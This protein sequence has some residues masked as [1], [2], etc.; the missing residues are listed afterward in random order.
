[1]SSTTRSRRPWRRLAVVALLVVCF[2]TGCA[3]TSSKWVALR[4]T[5]RNPLSDTLGLLTRQGPKPTPRTVQLLRRYD[6]EKDLKSD[7]K[8]LLARLEEVDAKEPSREH[9]Y[10]LAE[11]AYVGGKRAEGAMQRDKALELYGAAV[12]H[13]YHYLFDPKYAEQTNYYDPEFRSACDLYNAALESTMR[14]VQS[15]GNL[16]PGN[17]QLIQ[18]ANH[19]CHLKIE[20]VSRGWQPDDF[21]HF[22][23]VS[24]YEVHGLT[25]HYHTYGLGVPLVAVRKKHKEMDPSEEFYPEDLSFPVTAFLRVVSAP[26]AESPTLQAVLELHDPL[27]HPTVQVASAQVPLETDLSTPLAHTLNQPSLDDSKLSTLGLL[28]PE[29]VKSRQGLYM[30]EPFQADKIPVVMVHGLWSSPVTW[31]EMFNDLRSDPMVRQNYQFWFYLYPSGQPFWFSAAQMREDLAHMRSK[32]DPEQQHPALDQMVLVGHSMGGLVSKLQTIDSGNEFWRTLSERPFTELQAD[33]EVRDGLARTFF[34]DP[35]PSV[36]RV[37]TIGTPHRGSEFSNDA[38]RWLGRKL[39]HI[40]GKIMQGRNQLL[41]RNPN[42]FRPGAPLDVTTS[43]DSLSP[44]SPLLPVLLAAQH[45]PW[46]KYHNIVG[47]KPERGIDS[48]LAGGAG[49]GV[50]K[51]ASARLDN[52]QSQIVVP[53]DHSHVH[54]HPQSILEVRRI[55]LEHVAE[56][57]TFPYGAGVMQASAPG[58]PLSAAGPPRISTAGQS[59]SAAAP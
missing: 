14:V 35:N 45:G 3:S 28:K 53:A 41:A 22:E 57:R 56:L 46:V 23:F 27:D 39:I 20:L 33:E 58:L 15:Q 16:K 29:K 12:L 24:D 48:W 11:L 59:I 31:M 47:E 2:A 40:P 10:A 34:F 21:D 19:A 25:N 6:L 13:A 1:M 26:T 17:S 18:T 42:F 44:S 49:D 43:I 37:V 54:R 7:R 38:T 8:V 50:V 5:P 9:L 51:L 30:L 4:S 36:R 52:A 32:L 55:L